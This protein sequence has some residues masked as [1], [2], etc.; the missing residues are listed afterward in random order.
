MSKSLDEKNYLARNCLPL[1]SISK[2]ALEI[3]F[4]L[5]QEEAWKVG[6]IDLL[7]LKLL[8]VMLTVPQAF[9]WRYNGSRDDI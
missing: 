9:L 1:S 3:H 6:K 8:L 5:P 7:L 4:L 2:S